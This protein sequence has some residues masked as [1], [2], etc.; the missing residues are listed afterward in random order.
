MAPPDENV[1]IKD[2]RLMKVTTKQTYYFRFDIME[3]LLKA[4]SSLSLPA[5]TTT[6]KAC[7]FIF[8]LLRCHTLLHL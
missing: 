5:D 7:I 2:F 1:F 4:A 8:M 3:L 6:F